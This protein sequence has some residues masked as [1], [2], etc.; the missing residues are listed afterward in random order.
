MIGK[1]FEKYNYNYFLKKALDLVPNNI[2]K[3]EGSIIFDALAPCCMMLAEQMMLVRDSEL[4][5]F[6]ETSYG[7]YLD[8]IVIEEG[9]TRYAATKAKLKATIIFDGPVSGNELGY[10]FSSINK[11]VNINYRIID[12]LENN[13]N[14]IF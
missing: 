4:N 9:I 5:R 3:R 13:V 11:N 2:D 6:I 14:I 7:E 1:R 8:N 10:R 12:K